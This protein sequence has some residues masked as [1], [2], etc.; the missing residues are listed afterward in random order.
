M[1]YDF[2]FFSFLFC[3]RYLRGCGFL[4]SPNALGRAETNEE[5]RWKDGKMESWGGDGA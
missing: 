3:L 4:V 5:E 1:L 2:F